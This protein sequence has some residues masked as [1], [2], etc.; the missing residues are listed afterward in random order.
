MARARNEAP[1]ASMEWG[2]RRGVPSPPAM[3]LG[4]GYAPSPDFF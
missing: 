1:K 3:G 4:G 2:V